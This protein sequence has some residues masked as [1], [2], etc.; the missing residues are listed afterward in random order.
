M[1]TPQPRPK[2]YHHCHIAPQRNKSMQIK[3]AAQVGK[4]GTCLSSPL[5]GESQVKLIK[6]NTG[7]EEGV[8]GLPGL[9]Y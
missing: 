5:T 7:R 4:Q 2:D 9:C 6:E 8:S 3:I 1:L